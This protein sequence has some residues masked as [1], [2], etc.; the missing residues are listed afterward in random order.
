MKPAAPLVVLASALAAGCMEPARR[1]DSATVLGGR[2]FLEDQESRRWPL[3][4]AL[5]GPVVLLLGTPAVSDTSTLWDL[6][7]L[8]D[9]DR[10]GDVP[11]RRLL[12]LSGVPRI[13]ESVVKGRLRKSVK[14]PGSPVLLDWDGEAARSFSSGD[15]LPV[16]ILLDRAG[17]EVFR[18]GG[19]PDREKAHELR[20]RVAAVRLAAAGGGER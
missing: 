5:Q 15:P 20:A 7:C 19:S 3:P 1:D 13:L 2:R 4:D 9:I 16:V 12:D 17:R 6:D 10:N 8:V 14:P 11:V 18:S